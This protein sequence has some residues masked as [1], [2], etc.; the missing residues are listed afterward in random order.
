STVAPDRVIIDL[1]HFTAGELPDYGTQGCLHNAAGGSEDPSGSAALSH[2][3]VKLCVWNGSQ[4]DSA[5]FESFCRFSGGSNDI[6]VPSILNLHL[7]KVVLILFRHT[8]HDGDVTDILRRNTDL[9]RKIILHQSSEHLL[10]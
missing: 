9:L 10:G 1:I 7:R 4:I 3:L 5:Q 2:E 6:Y 8:R